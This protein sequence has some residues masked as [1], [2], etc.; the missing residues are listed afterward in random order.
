MHGAAKKINIKNNVYCAMLMEGA[1][2]MIKIFQEQHGFK[3]IGVYQLE[4]DGTIDG[5][6]KGVWPCFVSC[7]T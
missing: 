6:E 2:T 3:K 4:T 1:Q 5:A 7:A